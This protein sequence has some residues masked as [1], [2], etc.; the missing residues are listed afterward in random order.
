MIWSICVHSILCT[1]SMCAF[2]FDLRTFLNYIQQAQILAGLVCLSWACFLRCLLS[3]ATEVA[4]ATDF[5]L[6]RCEALMHEVWLLER[7]VVHLAVIEAVKFFFEVGTGGAQKIENILH[8]SWSRTLLGSY[9]M[10]LFSRSITEGVYRTHLRFCASWGN[11][12]YNLSSIFCI[13][14]KCF[15]SRCVLLLLSYI[16]HFKIHL[17]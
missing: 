9:N 5:Y 1:I 8:A 2:Y 6:A 12:R 11:T 10:N 7:S 3:H 15:C 14:E 4:M 13:S 16:H 17:F